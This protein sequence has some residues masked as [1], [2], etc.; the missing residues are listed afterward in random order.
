MFRNLLHFLNVKNYIYKLVQEKDF[1]IFNMIN[2]VNR[3]VANCVTNDGFFS[4]LASNYSMKFTVFA[5]FLSE[6]EKCKV[7]I[8][9]NAH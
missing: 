6:V 2:N 1:K 5:I 4:S 9:E 8:N 3:Y 7:F